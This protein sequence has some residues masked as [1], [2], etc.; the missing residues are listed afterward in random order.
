LHKIPE[1]NK[2]MLEPT[3]ELTLISIENIQPAPSPVLRKSVDEDL[4]AQHH[5]HVEGITDL[6]AINQM[7]QS[8]PTKT[9]KGTAEEGFCCVMSMHDGVVL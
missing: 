8:Q 4:N 6:S 9:E 7:D 2:E 5:H 1:E 3:T